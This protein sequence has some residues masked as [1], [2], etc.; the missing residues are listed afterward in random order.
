MRSSIQNQVLFTDPDRFLRNGC[1]TNNLPRPG[2]DQL[3]LCKSPPPV[4]TDFSDQAFPG[5]RRY[6]GSRRRCGFSPAELK[7][8]NSYL[9]LAGGNYILRSGSSRFTPKSAWL[10]LARKERTTNVAQQSFPVGYRHH[11]FFG[12]SGLSKADRPNLSGQ[13]QYGVCR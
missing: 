9:I 8:D 3:V 1:S 10:N 13:G 7:S 5:G 2:A 11:N 6:S 4:P 12:I